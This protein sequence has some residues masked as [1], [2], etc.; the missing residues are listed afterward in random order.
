VPYTVTVRTEDELGA[1]T[2][3]NVFL[4]IYGEF[5]QTDRHILHTSETHSN[6]FEKGQTDIFK[7]EAANV[8]QVSTLFMFS[9]YSHCWS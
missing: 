2:D 3:S 4:E 8:G 1:G 7:L 5:G 9:L 6:K